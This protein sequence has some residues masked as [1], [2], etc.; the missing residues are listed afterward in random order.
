MKKEEIV[1]DY[2]KCDRCGSDL[3]PADW[4]EDIEYD[5]NMIPTGRVRWA[6]GYIICPECGEFGLL[7]RS[8]CKRRQSRFF[9]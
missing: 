5:L 4:F 1:M 7:K 8:L 6:V 9:P 2:G 3:I